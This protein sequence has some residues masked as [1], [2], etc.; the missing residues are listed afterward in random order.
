ME[1]IVRTHHKNPLYL[2]LILLLCPF[3]G[4]SSGDER[5][6]SIATGGTGG[7]YYPYG[8]ALAEL[9]N[10]HVEGVRAVAE[11][12]SASVENA[13][14]VSSGEADIGFALA[15]TAYQA[16]SGTGI[17]ENRKLDQIRVLASI[18]PNALQVV[19]LENSSIYRIQDVIGHRV[20]VGAPGSGTEL[21]ARTVLAAFSISYDR[22]QPTRLNF[23]ET[24]DALRDGRIDAGIWSAAPPTGSILDLATAREIR[25]VSFSAEE[26]KKA[27]AT[28][29]VYFRYT[30]SAGTYPG[31]EEEILTTGTPNLLIVHKEMDEELGYQILR[32]L[33]DQ[34]DYLISVHPATRH[35]VPGYTL[36]TAPI[37]LHRGTRRYFQSNGYELPSHLEEPAQTDP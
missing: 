13:A 29:P 16:Y 23:N 7:V 10:R 5:L 20:S 36:E 34:L 11:V 6:M 12:T 32:T 25:L 9:I 21:T 22:F 19:T 1:E 8:G 24:A 15:D 4:C 35:T 31:Q 26:L 2:F 18:Y 3:I 30:I 37:P 14:L 17:F 27:L 28:D 33:Y